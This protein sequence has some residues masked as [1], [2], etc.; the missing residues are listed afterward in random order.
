MTLG[1]LERK[2]DEVH[3]DP[4]D[5]RGPLNAWADGEEEWSLEE[6]RALRDCDEGMSARG[7]LVGGGGLQ[8]PRSTRTLRVCNGELLVT[9]GPF[10]ETKKQIAGYSVL[11]CS[12]LEQAIEVAS[13]HPHRP[14]W[15]L[16]VAP[17]PQRAG[18]TRRISP[19]QAPTGRK[20]ALVLSAG[21]Q[22]DQIGRLD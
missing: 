14:H 6:D 3:A 21:R 10:A 17:V 20:N 9:D 12:D 19:V 8:P 5:R 15:H 11:E 22:S 4:L 1:R 7:I 16:R 2:N 13:P 18:V